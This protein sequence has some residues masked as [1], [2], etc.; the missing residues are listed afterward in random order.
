MHT[1]TMHTIVSRPAIPTANPKPSWHPS[2]QVDIAQ[3]GYTGCKFFQ[4]SNACVVQEMVAG[5]D[6][7]TL[8]AANALLA[9][10]F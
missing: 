7:T 1:T 6:V 4:R 9:W 2:K 10:L 3:A 8:A 5:T